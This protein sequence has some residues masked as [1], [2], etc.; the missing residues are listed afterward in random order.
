LAAPSGLKGAGQV[1]R[2][3]CIRCGEVR[4]TRTQPGPKA[5]NDGISAV[6]GLVVFG[7]AL[8]FFHYAGAPILWGGLALAA[9][10]GLIA[11]YLMLFG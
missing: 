1:Q 4:I 3:R 6:G 5:G 11:W 2:W 7:V 10:T 8:A 9:V